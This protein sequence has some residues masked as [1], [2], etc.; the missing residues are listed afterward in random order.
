[1]RAMVCHINSDA[2][3][4]VVKPASKVAR[5]LLLLLSAAAAARPAAPEPKKTAGYK[6]QLSFGYTDILLRFGDF[7]DS[8][9]CVERFLK[10]YFAFL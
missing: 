2:M 3:H 10:R 4:C 5:S 1:M 8:S 7:G 6:F 9:V